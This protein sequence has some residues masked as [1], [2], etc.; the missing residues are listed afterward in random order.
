MITDLSGLEISSEE[1]AICNALGC[2]PRHIDMIS[3]ETGLAP[4]K[5][6]GTLLALELKGIVRQAEGKRFYIL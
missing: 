2:E 5:L 3:R 4:Q 1:K 6:L